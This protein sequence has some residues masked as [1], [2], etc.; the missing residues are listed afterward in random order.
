MILHALKYSSNSL[1]VKALIFGISKK[2]KINSTSLFE[3]K[4]PYLYNIF[5]NSF[6]LIF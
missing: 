4:I 3:Y 6:E 5:E 1:K 2:F